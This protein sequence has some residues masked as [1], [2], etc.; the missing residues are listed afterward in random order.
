MRLNVTDVFHAFAP[1]N[2]AFPSYCIGSM[3]IDSHND[4]LGLCFRYGFLC[5]VS[6]S[7]GVL[8]S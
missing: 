2:H 1:V 4:I 8:M 7:V 3:Y 6:V 5:L